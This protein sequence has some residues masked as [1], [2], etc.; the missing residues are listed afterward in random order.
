M[1]HDCNEHDVTRTDGDHWQLS[2]VGRW[3]ATESDER[4]ARDVLLNTRDR[5]I[6]REALDTARR[7]QSGGWRL[8]VVVHSAARRDL[9]QLP[10]NLDALL[11]E[12]RS[13][14]TCNRLKST[15]RERK[16][17]WACTGQADAQETRMCLRC[18]RGGNFRESWDL[19]NDRWGQMGHVW[20]RTSV[21]R[22][23]W[24][25]RSFIAS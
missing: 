23:G 22:Y 5:I 8:I 21:L 1:P 25:I 14:V 10:V 16:D 3:K 12:N 9:E 24:C 20:E 7:G 19:R 15:C 11:A 6:M 17:S 18:D 13:S 4:Y 2:T